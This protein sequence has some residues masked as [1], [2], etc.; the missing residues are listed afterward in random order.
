MESLKLLLGAI[1]G[2][3]AAA[4][5]L[6]IIPATHGELE[7]V[8]SDDAAAVALVRSDISGKIDTTRAELNGAINTTRAELKGDLNTA[9]A[10]LDAID[11]GVK[12]CLPAPLLLSPRSNLNSRSRPR[13]SRHRPLLP[14]PHRSALALLPP[15]RSRKAPVLS[16][17]L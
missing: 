17:G 9:N 6:Y 15:Q 12:G 3:F 10:R 11:S 14:C 4:L 2:P 13:R 5:L 1:F 8:K 7:I 16:P